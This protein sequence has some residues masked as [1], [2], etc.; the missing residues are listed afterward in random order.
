MAWVVEVAV[1]G[2]AEVKR[3]AAVLVAKVRVDSVFEEAADALRS[4]VLGRESERVAAEQ[5]VDRVDGGVGVDKLVDH[6]EPLVVGGEGERADP[7]LQGRFGGEPVGD[8]SDGGG[9]LEPCG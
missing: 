4:P 8:L 5:L 6:R 1:G 9:A 3:G 7:G 2:L